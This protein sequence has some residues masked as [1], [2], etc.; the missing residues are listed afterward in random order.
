MGIAASAAGAARLSW[1]YFG[2]GRTRLEQSRVKRTARPRDLRGAGRCVGT[3]WVYLTSVAAFLF[4]LKLT[5]N[6]WSLLRC[7]FWMLAT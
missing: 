7:V 2:S 3:G 1:V 4:A 5:Y 6:G